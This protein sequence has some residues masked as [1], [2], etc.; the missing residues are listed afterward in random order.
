MLQVFAFKCDHTDAGCVGLQVILRS[1][2]SQI[3]P[4]SPSRTSAVAKFCIFLPG[5]EDLSA[6]AHDYHFVT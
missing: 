2:M 1:N 3:F 6:H 5:Y 4:K